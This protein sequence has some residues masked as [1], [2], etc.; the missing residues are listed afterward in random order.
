MSSESRSI[1]VAVAG[2]PNSGK[3]TI[4]NMLTGA[5]QHVANYPGVTVEKKTGSFRLKDDRVE[6]I[7]L[8]GTHSL[9][10]Y[11]REERIARDFLPDSRWFSPASRRFGRESPVILRRKTG[12]VSGKGGGRRC[13]EPGRCPVDAVASSWGGKFSCRPGQGGWGSIRGLTPGPTAL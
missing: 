4:F 7:D 5:R 2:Q 3:S 11:T 10:S 9:T 6:L 12:A 8:P 1:M 13:L